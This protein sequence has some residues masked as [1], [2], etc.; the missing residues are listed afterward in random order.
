MLF[1]TGEAYSNLDLTKVTH[2]NNKL[3]TV[4]MEKVIV[5]VSP[6]IFSDWENT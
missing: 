4:E 5:R 6:N 3:S 2:N 1:Q